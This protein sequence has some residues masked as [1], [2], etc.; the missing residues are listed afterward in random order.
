MTQELEDV[1]KFVHDKVIP[2]MRAKEE[3]DRKVKAA[4]AE[5]IDLADE[6]LRI[7]VRP[8]PKRGVP[9][10]QEGCAPFSRGVSPS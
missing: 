9:P 8:L 6:R 7:Q 5:A 3:V 2:E 1:S 10:S 4:E